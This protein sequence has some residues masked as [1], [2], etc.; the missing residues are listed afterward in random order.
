MTLKSNASPK[1]TSSPFYMKNEQ[2][3]KQWESY[4]SHKNG[5]VK[6]IFNASSFHL[7]AK[8]ETSSLWE[9]Q[10][11]KATYSSGNLL[12]SSKY[13]NLQE[14]LT[15]KTKIPSSTC[16][17]FKICKSVFKRKSQKHPLYQMVYDLCAE[18]LEKRRLYQA[19]FNKKVL[20][21]TYHHCNDDFDLVEKVLNLGLNSE[22]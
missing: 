13:Q 19:E 18:D 4:A 16:G 6:G 17:N 20:T 15:F 7:L 21:F 10:V 1:E 3:C 9:I 14:I 8:I 11:K 12:L 22:D 5:T 2:L